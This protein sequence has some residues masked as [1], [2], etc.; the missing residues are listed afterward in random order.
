MAATA[1]AAEAAAAAAVSAADHIKSTRHCQ[2]I[3]AVT[4]Y[5]S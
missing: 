4:L 2:R 1:E 5:D 3:H